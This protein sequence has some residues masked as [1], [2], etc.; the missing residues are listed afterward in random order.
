MG[1]PQDEELKTSR[2]KNNRLSPHG[3]IE[4]GSI[5]LGVMLTQY[6]VLACAASLGKRVTNDKHN[7]NVV[8]CFL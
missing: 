6:I 5:L 2:A 4:D 3:C 7:Q 8:T 1:P